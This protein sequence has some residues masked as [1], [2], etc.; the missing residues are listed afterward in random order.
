MFAVSR[1]VILNELRSARDYLDRWIGAVSSEIPGVDIP[2]SGD[3]DVK[4]DS[5]VRELCGELRVVSG[6]CDTLAEVLAES[7]G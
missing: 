5:F 1:E 2:A 4:Q 3:V 6:K 7:A